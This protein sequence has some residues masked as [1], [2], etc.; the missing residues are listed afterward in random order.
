M[1]QTRFCSELDVGAADTRTLH[2]RHIVGANPV[3]D[4]PLRQ[5]YFL[6]DQRKNKAQQDA[7]FLNS[8]NSRKIKIIDAMPSFKDGLR[9]LLIV[10]ISFRVSQ[11]YFK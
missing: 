6:K 7:G 1:D 4:I 3:S 10:L 9:Q 8:T 5:Y 11:E 2:V